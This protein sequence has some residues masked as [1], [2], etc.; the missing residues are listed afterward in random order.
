MRV[1]ICIY[2]CKYPPC[3][4]HIYILTF[5]TYWILLGSPQLP[6]LLLKYYSKVL[7]TPSPSRLWALMFWF[8]RDKILKH[9]FTPHP[10][11]PTPLSLWTFLKTSKKRGFPELGKSNFWQIIQPA[12]ACRKASRPPSWRPPS[13]TYTLPRSQRQSREGCGCKKVSCVKFR[14]FRSRFGT[15]HHYALKDERDAA[16]FLKCV[17]FV[18]KHF[19]Q[20]YLYRVFTGFV[21]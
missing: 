6:L 16:I 4:L 18:L 20:S 17:L 3:I 12:Q 9:R 15:D 5:Y 13:P 21:S 2:L 19:S 10:P 14:A 11:A 8:P 1:N 7:W